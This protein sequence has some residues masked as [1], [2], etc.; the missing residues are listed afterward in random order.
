MEQQKDRPPHATKW[1]Q[2]FW[3]TIAALIVLAYL[4]AWVS[5][6]C[7]LKPLFEGYGANISSSI[8]CGLL[9]LFLA[10]YFNSETEAKVAETRDLAAKSEAALAKREAILER[11][12]RIFEFEQFLKRESYHNVRFP[13]LKPRPD[14]IGLEYTIRPYRDPVLNEPAV[15]ENEM[16]RLYVVQVEGPAHWS[17]L[18]DH[19]KREYDTS[20]IRDGEYYFCRFFNDSWHMGTENVF[21]EHEFYLSGKVGPAT[22]GQSATDFVSS[23]R[24][25][26][27]A[28]TLK[29][30][31]YLNPEGTKR[32]D[33]VS[34]DSYRIYTDTA[35]NVYLVVNSSMPKQ[36]YY[37]NPEETYTDT[38][39]YEVIED[40]RG[41][42]HGEKLKN[43][44]KAVFSECQRIGLSPK[45]IPWH[46]TQEHKFEPPN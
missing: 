30:Q 32:S 42:A 26:L 28:M 9:L 21:S 27:E 44:I 1:L 10:L 41:F 14:S 12:R 7:F 40:I 35:G 24:K 46:Q 31:I 4:M 15:Y 5:P 39:W 43:I 23:V 22:Y 16:E 17:V 19:Q 45:K 34:V 25:P 2:F 20:P 8:L 33:D 18:N 38:G 3:I 6:P 29:A 13:K 36:M 11:E 37:T